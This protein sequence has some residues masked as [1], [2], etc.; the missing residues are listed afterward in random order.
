MKP[1][2]R[3]LNVASAVRQAP[4]GHVHRGIDSCL[5]KMK[6]AA[7][8]GGETAFLQDEGY[9]FVNYWAMI[10]RRIMFSVAL[11]TWTK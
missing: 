1:P 5:P 4:S 6:K 7:S 10:S 2:D 3:D 9:A 11:E 8:P